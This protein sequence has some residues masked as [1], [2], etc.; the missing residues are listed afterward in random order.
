MDKTTQETNI[1]IL[2]LT[3]GVKVIADRDSYI[4][5]LF[6]EGTGYVRHNDTIYDAEASD[7]IILR[8]E[9]SIYLSPSH[10]KTC[11]VYYLT[12][13][14][15]QLFSPGLL[16]GCAELIRSFLPASAAVLP[17]I[18]ESLNVV[19]NLFSTCR[20]IADDKLPYARHLI[21]QTIGVLVLY[22]ARLYNVSNISHKK[23]REPAPHTIMTE[24]VCQYVRQNYSAPVSLST[25]AEL[26]H[27][28]PSYLSRVFKESTGISLVSYINQVRIEA[29]KYMLTDTDELVV[30]IASA[31][32]FNY[33]PHFNKI[34]KKMTGMSPVQYKKANQ[35]P[36]F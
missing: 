31:C 26:V 24:Q 5:L 16:P 28:N 1:Q 2:R 25:L 29:A 20:L 32:G 34:F 10:I 23:S 14:E 8:G 30:D 36:V 9:D 13:Y 18:G 33:V 17:L 4:F 7:C 3:R 21:S 12:F 27:T 35:K 22:L 11:T 19:T 15:N 6:T